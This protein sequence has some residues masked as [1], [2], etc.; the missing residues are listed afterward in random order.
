MINN[1]YKIESYISQGSF[2]I[3]YKCSYNNKSYAVKC[4]NNTELLKYEANIYKELRN[5]SNVSSL[6]DCF[7]Y[8]NKYYLVLELYNLNLINLK[9]RFINSQNYEERLSKIMIKVVD[10][11]RNIHNAG[12]VHRDLKPPNICLNNNL[13]PFIVDFGM[14]KKIINNNKHIEERSIHNIIG[15]PNYVSLNVIN[16][17]EPSRRDDMESLIYIIIYMILDNREYVNYT[18]NNLINQKS[19]S[20]VMEVLKYKNNSKLI[21]LLDYI[22]KLNFS[23]IPN[24][25]YIKDKL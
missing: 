21:E 7:L 8:E 1:K 3:V 22:R 5:V 19:V 13:E 2:G 10:I 15:S 12:I 25:D 17:K 23:Q 20:K 11:L 14:A 24:Y 16:L 9:D 4:D 18:N 6:I